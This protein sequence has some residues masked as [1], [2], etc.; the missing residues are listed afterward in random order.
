MGIWDNWFLQHYIRNFALMVC[1]V[2]GLHILLYR[3]K[4]Q[5]DVFRFDPR[6]F[7]KNNKLFAFNNQ[8]WDNILWSL[9][10]GVIVWTMYEAFM[11][12]AYA[13]D[14]LPKATFAENPIWFCALFIILPAWQSIHF[15]FIHR[16]LHWKPLYRIAHSVHHRNTNIG[17]WSGFSMHPVEHM[18]YLSYIFIV[19]ILPA[20][21][22][23]IIFMLQFNSVGTAIGH[24]GFESLVIFKKLKISLS[25][26][27]HQLHHRYFDCNYGNAGEVPLD[28]WMGTFHDG[29]AEGMAHMR[30]RQKRDK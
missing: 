21:P 14:L 22:L 9:A 7:A 20:H 3:L 25:P 1:V 18:L 15:F 23:H 26:F 17:P 2:G 6:P 12:W 30:A 13:S 4:W 24:A 29:T 28:K 11:L 27:D 19:F 8:V 16:F 5:N 10:S